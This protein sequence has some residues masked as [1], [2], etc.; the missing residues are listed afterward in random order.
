VEIIRDGPVWPYQ[1][2]ADH[3]RR[4]IEAGEYQPDQRL[5]S[6]L[7]LMQTYGVA[8]ETARKAIRVLVAEELAYVLQG[9]GAFVARR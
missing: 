1:Q 9:H 6:E 4:A 3:L 5:P 8:R 7:T 2:I